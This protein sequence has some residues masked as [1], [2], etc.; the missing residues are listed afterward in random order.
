MSRKG[1][2]HL[3]NT[4]TETEPSGERD[5]TGRMPEADDAALRKALFRIASVMLFGTSRMN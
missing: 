2:R 3:G 4:D 5:V 1:Y